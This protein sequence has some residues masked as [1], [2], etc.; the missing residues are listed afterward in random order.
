MKKISLAI[1]TLLMALGVAWAQQ[2]SASDSDNNTPANSGSQVTVKGCLGGSAG[3]FTLLGSDGMTYQLQGDDNQLKEHVG[4]T[5]SVTGIVGTG[6]STTTNSNETNP[7]GTSPS[8]NSGEQRTLSVDSLQH[9]SASCSQT[10][11]GAKQ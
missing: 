6:N 9:I 7:S 10:T 2:P 8:A 5:V 1:A 3:N 11:T 4:H